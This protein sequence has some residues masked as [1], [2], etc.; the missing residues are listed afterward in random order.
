M[1]LFK[2]VIV[3]LLRDPVLCVER[4][5]RQF[6]TFTLPNDC[7]HCCS[8][9]PS[10]ICNTSSISATTSCFSR[11]TLLLF[12]ELCGHYLISERAL[13]V[14]RLLSAYEY[15]NEGSGHSRSL[16]LYDKILRRRLIAPTDRFRQNSLPI[17]Q[18]NSPAAII[19]NFPLSHYVKSFSL[20]SHHFC[21][22][23]ACRKSS[24]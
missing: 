3:H 17:L 11:K 2:P 22:T 9:Y 13:K 7:I 21:G 1:H 12:F 6:A 18:Q 19:P 24:K 4:F 5:V 15:T 23:G 8:R 20:F 10:R 16:L 14:G